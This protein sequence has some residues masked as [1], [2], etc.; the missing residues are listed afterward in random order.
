M[1]YLVELKLAKRP[2]TPEEGIVFIEQSILPTLELCK[3]LAAETKIVAGGPVSGAI[4]ISLIVRADS[5]QALDD[6]ISSLPVWPLM[7]TKVTPLN[8]FDG[9]ILAVRERLEHLKAQRGDL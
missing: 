5:V 3:K 8:T 7:K 6:L 2:A 9:R 4:A 1:D